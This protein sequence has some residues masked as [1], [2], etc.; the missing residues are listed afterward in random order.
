MKKSNWIIIAILVAAS[1]FFLWLWYALQ[2]NLVDNPTDL[3]ISVIWWVV[4][5]AACAAIHFAEQKRQER[6]RA[7]YVA[8]APECLYVG[9]EGTV[10]VVEGNRYVDVLQGMLEGL[11]YGFDIEDFPKRSDVSFCAIVR[12]K[13]FKVDKDTEMKAE[14]GDGSQTLTVDLEGE[15]TKLHEVKKWE[16]EVVDLRNPDDDPQKFSNKEEL[17]ALI[18]AVL[19]EQPEGDRASGREDMTPFLES[20]T[21]QPA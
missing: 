7:A 14:E 13:K 4:V 3:V 16:G 9:E 21:V 10:Q 12:S 11:D 18:K 17:A 20:L 1:A 15:D 6:I 8:S 19:P 5:L 2:L